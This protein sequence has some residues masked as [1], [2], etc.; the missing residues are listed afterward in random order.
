M[1]IADQRVSVDQNLAALSFVSLSCPLVSSFSNFIEVSQGYKIV[2]QQPCQTKF[3][4]DNKIIKVLPAPTTVS[5]RLERT[6]FSFF[7]T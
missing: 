1:L 4:D 6:S 7:S 3:Y 5:H 2:E